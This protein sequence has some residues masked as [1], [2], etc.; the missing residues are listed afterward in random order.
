MGKKTKIYS[1]ALF[2]LCG[3]LI[4]GAQ[5][6]CKHTGLNYSQL[7]TVCYIRDVFPVFITSCGTIGCHDPQTASGHYVLTNYQSII[8]GV[9]PFDPNKSIVYRAIIAD[10]ESLMPPGHALT[11]SQ[12]IFIRV[13]IGQGAD[14]TTCP[15]TLNKLAAPSKMAKIKDTYETE[16]TSQL[17]SSNSV[18]FIN[19]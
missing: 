15:L 8:R 10:G 12:R 7:D 17:T 1:S 13:W 14:S 4:I 3:L 9:T 19:N 5:S 16:W 18:S 11:E 2:T 6:S